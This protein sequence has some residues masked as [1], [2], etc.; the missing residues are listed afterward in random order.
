L[1]KELVFVLSLVLVVSIYAQNGETITI[2]HTNDLHSRLLGYAPESRYSPL[3]VNDDKTTGGFARIASILKSEKENAQ[4]QTLVLDAGD[5]TMGTLFSSLESKTG[6]QL[7]LMKEMGYEVLGVGNHPGI[8]TA[9][10]IYRVMPLGSGED[11]VPGYALSRLYFTGKELKSIL[12]ILI[13]SGKSN[14]QYFC[15]IRD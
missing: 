5:F 3:T 6:F 15:F 14:P 8:Q 11:A 1:K 10:D 12:E 9:Q 13:M 2:L 4:G 7:C